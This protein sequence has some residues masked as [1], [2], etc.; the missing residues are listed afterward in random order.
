MLGPKFVSEAPYFAKIAGY[1]GGHP[2]PL[3]SRHFTSDRTVSMEAYLLYTE[4]K[5]LCEYKYQTAS[6]STVNLLKTIEVFHRPIIGQ[7][8]LPLKIT[9]VSRVNVKL[10]GVYLRHDLN[11]S[12]HVDALLPL[13]VKD[14][15]CWHDLKSKVLA[16]TVSSPYTTGCGKIK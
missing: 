15:I 14:F 4:S 8:L 7:D 1:K 3:T 11:F 10:L 6:L 16:Y 12:Q 5:T 13:V 9:N 2:R